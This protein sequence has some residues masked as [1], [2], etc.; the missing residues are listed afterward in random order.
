VKTTYINQDQETYLNSLGY[1]A[2]NVETLLSL[3]KKQKAWI[4]FLALIST[5]P[6]PLQETK[7]WF[8]AIWL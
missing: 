7:K 2:L 3:Y 6:E 5:L 1:L 4:S 8:V